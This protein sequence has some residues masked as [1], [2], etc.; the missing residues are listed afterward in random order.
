MVRLNIQCLM[1]FSLFPVLSVLVP[2]LPRPGSAGPAR[3]T[4]LFAC[5]TSRQADKVLP[6]HF[7][8]LAN[9]NPGAC[10]AF[11][12]SSPPLPLSRSHSLPFAA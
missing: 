3:L 12:L 1:L 6:P 7:P 9:A 2:R 5:R 11:H 4:R 8:C 10:V